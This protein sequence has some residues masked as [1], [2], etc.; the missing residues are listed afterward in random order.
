MKKVV[1]IIVSYFN[2]EMTCRF[3]MEEL[4]KCKEIACA[5]VVNNSADSH[6]DELLRDGM[7]GAVL[8]QREE[9]YR[10]ESIVII[11]ASENQGFARGNN[12]GAAFARKYLEPDYL[13]FTNDDILITDVEVVGKM[14]G[15]MEGDNQIGMIGP[16]IK[17]PDSNAP[18]GPIPYSSIWKRYVWPY[19]I[20]LPF[21]WYRR[22]MEQG[23]MEH[24]REGFHYVVLGCFFL[25]R[26]ADFYGIDMMDPHTFLYR[27]EE[28]LSERMKA[29]YGK[30]A[31]WY[32]KTEVVHLKS[33]TTDPGHRHQDLVYARQVVSDLYY[34]H[35]YRGVPTWEINMAVRL[36]RMARDVR[37]FFSHKLFHGN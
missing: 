9:D 31:Y 21:A 6:S 25:M 4:R 37:F 27:E 35:A 33:V 34:Y 3:V 29:F 11:P 24:A 18:Q 17:L 12:Q 7:P 5:V 30:M 8:L 20:P 16:R 1:A 19:A 13:L 2:E 28:C 23:Y 26:A 32:P 22:Y 14:I 15:K 10:G 36:G